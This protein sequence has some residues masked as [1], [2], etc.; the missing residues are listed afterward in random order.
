[1]PINIALTAFDVCALFVVVGLLACRMAVVP[2]GTDRV[3]DTR[4]LRLLGAGILL[5]TLSSIGILISRV[6]ELDG[7]SWTQLLPSLPP[8]LKVTHYGRIWPWRIPALVLLWFAW[9][10]CLRHREHRWTSWLMAIAVA[11]IALTRSETGHPADHGDFTVAVWTDWVHLMAA[12]VWVGSLFGV[13]LVVF[14]RLL[15]AE[16]AAPEFSAAIFRRLSTLAGAALALVLA[17]GIYTAIGQLGAFSGLWTSSYGITLDVKVFIVIVMIVLGTH[18]RYIKLP[19]LM[20]AAG[21]PPPA[22]LFGK[23]FTRFTLRHAAHD[24]DRDAA[25]VRSCARAVLAESVLGLTVIAAA[26]VLL[27]NMPPADMPKDIPGMYMQMQTRT[28]PVTVPPALTHTPD[29]L[30]GAP[31]AR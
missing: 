11:G 26:S 23:L 22:S 2:H 10:W 9:G 13:S 17:A 18:N 4:L 19:R 20:R 25:V 16:N 24:G 3:L 28:Q 15:R 1:M 21:K 27:H 5:L 7:G 8:A 29:A 30:S 14:P 31:V 12:A 6:L